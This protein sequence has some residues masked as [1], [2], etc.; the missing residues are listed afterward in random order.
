MQSGLSS[1]ELGSMMSELTKILKYRLIAHFVSF[2]QIPPILKICCILMA[3]QSHG[4]YRS[5]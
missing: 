4:I 3:G 5:V 2:S 1:N